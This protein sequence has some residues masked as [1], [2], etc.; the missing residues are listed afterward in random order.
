MFLSIGLFGDI[1]VLF[2][3][4]STDVSVLA[5]ADGTPLLS[6]F[7]SPITSLSL[8]P[9]ALLQQLPGSVSLNE[10]GRA[11]LSDRTCLAFSNDIINGSCD[12]YI[13][14]QTPENSLITQGVDYYQK[15]QDRVSWLNMFEVVCWFLFNISTGSPILSVNS[16]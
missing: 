15:L 4:Q 10:C 12:L 1:R 14:T 9:S 5:L 11:C 3:V 2:N 7:D 13:E 16:I 8:L 6:Y